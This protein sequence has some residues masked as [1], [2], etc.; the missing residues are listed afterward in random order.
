[1]TI[2][3]LSIFLENKPETLY[4][5]TETLAVNKVNMRA[6]SLADSSDFGIARI[7]CDTPD[8]VADKLRGEDY[9]VNVTDVLAVE[10]PDE[11]GS[12][13]KIL[14]VLSENNRNVEYMYGFTGRK[15]NTA[16]MIM[17]CTD[18]AKAE[19]VLSSAGIKFISQ[20]ELLNI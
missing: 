19:E 15:T 14:K 1:M 3:Q 9:I 5:L 6:L 4:K 11:A 16:C 10:I 18:V 7:I 20:E 2:K 8:A 13:N 17:R 12:L